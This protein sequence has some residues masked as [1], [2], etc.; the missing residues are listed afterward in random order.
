MQQNLHQK[1]SPHTNQLVAL[2]LIQGEKEEEDSA[3]VSVCVCVWVSDKSKK[4][5][6]LTVL[7]WQRR[8]VKSLYRPP[9][10]MA[11]PYMKNRTIQS[12]AVS[13]EESIPDACVDLISY[14][15]LNYFFHQGVNPQTALSQ[16]EAVK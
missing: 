12:T 14:L 5:R 6:G 3:R 16:R 2:F 4:G 1:D 13:Q 9:F 7:P 15:V 10:F 8:D 11:N